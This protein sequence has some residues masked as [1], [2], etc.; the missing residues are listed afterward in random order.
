MGV[1]R[2]SDLAVVHIEG[3]HP[4]AAAFRSTSKLDVGDIVLALGNPLGLR[5][6]VTNGIVSALNRTV[7]APNGN[8]LPSMIQTSAPINPGNSGGALVDLGGKVVGIPTIAATDPEL[9][10]P[11]PGIGFAIPSDIVRDVAGQIIEYGRVVH[12][13]RA[14]LG[15]RLSPSYGQGSGDALV[16]GVDAYGPADIAGLQPGDAIVAI[17]GTGIASPAALGVALAKRSPGQ[18]VSV[19]YRRDGRSQTAQVTLGE[20]PVRAAQG[21]S[22][23]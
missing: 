17:D 1:D 11:A 14:Y 4:R 12:S 19:R 22:T 13:H 15:V 5:S 16:V 23:G 3:E 2:V 6:S 20:F 8:A 10:G 18:R 9:G 7:A 21:D